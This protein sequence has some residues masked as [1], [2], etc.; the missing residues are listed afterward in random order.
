M[1]F[2]IFSSVLPLGHGTWSVERTTWSSHSG[3]GQVKLLILNCSSDHSAY[4]WNYWVKWTCWDFISFNFKLAWWHGPK[5]DGPIRG[6]TAR[7]TAWA[8]GADAGSADWNVTGSENT[9]AP[10]NFPPK[11]IALFNLLPD[12]DHAKL[13]HMCFCS[14][15]KTT[16]NRRPWRWTRQLNF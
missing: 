1:V 6:P 5:K 15:R 11:H 13:V 16:F 8:T 12:F 2:L 14:W 4:S 9:S 7:W 10:E 3:K